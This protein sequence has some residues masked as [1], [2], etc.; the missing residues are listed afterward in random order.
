MTQVKETEDELVVVRM[1][2]QEYSKESSIRLSTI[3]LSAVR[4]TLEREEVRVAMRGRD[5][6]RWGKEGR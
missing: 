4:S 1:K 5:S 3:H 6:S 2:H